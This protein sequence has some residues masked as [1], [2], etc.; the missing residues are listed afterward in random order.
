MKEILG[1]LKELKRNNNREWFAAN[2]DRYE[3]VK[4]RVGA[5]TS[6]LLLQL[7]EIEPDA[8]RLTTADCT[9]RIY[10]DTRFSLDKTPYKTHIGIFMNPPRGKKSLRCGYYLHIEPGNCFFAAGTIGHPSDVLKALRRSIYDE[11]DEYRSIVEDPD[12]K[13]YFTEIGFDLL[14]TAPKGID[15]DWPY[16]DYVRPRNFT[17]SAPLKESQLIGKSFSPLMGE[18]MRQA[19][20]F[21]DFMNFTIDDFDS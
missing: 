21:N 3:R 4:E 2:K 20:R 18:L 10:R 15:R 14:K 5:L 1:F 12:F 8:S 17:A 9:Y 13:Q 11:I 16:I 6:E 7:S 19:K